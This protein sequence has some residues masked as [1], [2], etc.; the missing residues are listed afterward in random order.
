ML[1]RIVEEIIHYGVK[2]LF[3]NEDDVMFVRNEILNELGLDKPYDGDHLRFDEI[4]Y[5]DSPTPII[6]KLK[7]EMPEI[8]DR[9]IE[10]IMSFITPMPS[11]L[12]SKFKELKKDSVEDA[13][14][15]FYYLM[16]RNNYIKVD[17]KSVV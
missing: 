1:E 10:K 13:T 7:E 6:N 12:I 2:H 17:R 3:L 15:Y 4:D 14:S 9:K 5:L 11:Q 8:D 16:T